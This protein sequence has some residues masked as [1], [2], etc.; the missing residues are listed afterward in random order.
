M[1]L[2]IKKV[3][4]ALGNDR[5][6]ILIQLEDSVL[7]GIIAISEG[8]PREEAMHTLYTAISSLMM[9]LNKDGNALSW[10]DLPN[11]E[12]S[13]FPSTPSAPNVA[14]DICFHLNKMFQGQWCLSKDPLAI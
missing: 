2:T 12:T 13:E 5:P 11:T 9:D 4:N 10:F 8:I 6:E 14:E 1:L 7:N 3:F